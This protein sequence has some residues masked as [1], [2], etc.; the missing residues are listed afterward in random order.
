MSVGSWSG[1]K[2]AALAVGLAL[3]FGALVALVINY[4]GHPVTTGDFRGASER[5]RPA[6]D[7]W[8]LV[9]WPSVAGTK[10][11]CLFPQRSPSLPSRA[12]VDP[13]AGDGFVPNK[14][15]PPPQ[16]KQDAA[17]P[18]EPAA[19][20]KRQ[21]KGTAGEPAAPA[22]GGKNTTQPEAPAKQGDKGSGEDKGSGGQ[23]RR[24]AWR[25]A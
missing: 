16:Q 14:P 2:K 10:A 17:P 23:G 7:G 15:K 4:R 24:L 3:L 18:K 19:G 25:L 21:D 5:R 20:A 9:V 12:V 13:E 6:A 1:K 11:S 22:A 8:V